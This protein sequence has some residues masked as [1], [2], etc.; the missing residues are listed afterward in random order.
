MRFEFDFDIATFHHSPKSSI[1][2][3]Q[4]FRTK[5]SMTTIDPN[6]LTET[7]F[8]CQRCSAAFS[9][10]VHVPP[11]PGD[12]FVEVRCAACSGPGA[13]EGS[14]RHLHKSW[15]CLTATAMYNLRRL[16]GGSATHFRIS[17][18]IAPYLLA[19]W[20]T[21]CVGRARHRTLANTI[22]SAITTSAHVFAPK[23]GAGSGVW[24]LIG[25]GE[26]AF[27]KRSRGRL[28][29]PP[30]SAPAISL[31]RS[32]GRSRRSSALPISNLPLSRSANKALT[33]RA[34]PALA[35]E[36][37]ASS[38]PSVTRI[39]DDE[40]LYDDDDNDD[41]NDDLDDADDD[42]LLFRGL[43]DDDVN[44]RE[45]FRFSSD[46][47]AAPAS[48]VGTI[49]FAT[50]DSVGDLRL[51]VASTCGCEA[52]AVHLFKLNAEFSNG[53]PVWRAQDRNDAIK[54]WRNAGDSVAFRTGQAK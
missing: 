31:S 6:L 27:A 5:R 30:P 3:L 46:D 49:D 34:R 7:A 41:D 8:V 43:D 26:L 33:K 44:V 23:H 45:L 35:H 1:P 24:G 47:A 38:A 19:H 14:F 20:N 16:S 32:A 29:S 42:D 39:R 51:K 18:D 21:L 2:N 50:R 54:Y 53:V 15:V 17:Q 25:D 52:A 4:L 37:R 12:V 13:R 28:S 11:C 22:S 36:M 10:R 9:L 48:L 40:H